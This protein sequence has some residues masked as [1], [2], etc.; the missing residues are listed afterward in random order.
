MKNKLVLLS[1]MLLLFL[2]MACTSEQE[3]LPN[4]C[5]E[6]PV[7]GLTSS[8]Q[9]TC[10]Q[11]NGSLTVDA[12]GGNGAILYSI[13][14][15]V[16]QTSGSFI[17]LAA[18]SYTLVLIDENGCSDQLLA[19]VTNGDGLNIGL[20]VVGTACGE[21]QGSILVAS[22]D[23]VGTVSYKLNEGTFQSSNM[24]QNLPQGGYIITARDG[25]GCEIQQEVDIKTDATFGEVN[26]LVQNNCAIT[27]C[28]SGSQ[29]PDLRT[30]ASIIAN[31]DRIKIR[32]GNRSMPVGGGSLTDDEIATIACWVDDGAAGN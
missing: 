4:L 24:F 26:L 32:T 29:S 19:N 21:N 1:L 22:S 18:G 9:A 15:G 8:T 6:A 14:G 10:N 13:N 7:I 17:G 23:E 20:T 12:S 31:A 28:H 3:P 16:N 5:D 27:G 2:V 25:S 30:S 11:N